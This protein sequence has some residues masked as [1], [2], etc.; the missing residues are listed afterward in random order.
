MRLSPPLALAGVVL[1]MIFTVVAAVAVYGGVRL[2]TIQA[3]D[4]AALPAFDPLR[5]RPSPTPIGVVSVAQATPTAIAAAIPTAVGGEPEPT[6]EV[7]VDPAAGYSAWSDPNRVNILLLGIDQRRGEQG[8]FR[9]DT[10]IVLSVDPVR[11]SAVMLSI[12]RDLWVS[13][14]GFAPGRIN[15]ANSLGD[16]Y[17]F[18]G[19][20]PALAAQTVERNLGIRI[21]HTIRVNFDLFL[22]AVEAIAPVEICVTETIHDEAYPDGSYGIMTV[23]FDPGCQPMNAEQLLQYARVRHTQGGDFDRARR[24]QQ[25]ITAARDR[26][27]SLGGVQALL[28]Q[29]PALWEAARQDI[30]T[31]LSFEQLVSLALL[32]QDI[33][34]ENITQAVL[35][36]NYVYFETTAS[37]DQVLRLRGD[38]MRRLVSD[39]FNPVKM[40]QEDLRALAASETA[41]LSVVNGTTTQ[42]L[43]AE[44]RDWLQA[45]GFNVVEIGNAT[46]SGYAH[47]VIKD[48]TNKPYTARLLA[49]L[50]GLPVTAVQPGSDNATVQDIQIVVGE[51]L[52]PLL[53]GQ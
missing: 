11:R 42:G 47:T 21:H 41:T 29:A 24:Q 7:Q 17:D 12:P 48:Y 35:D 20:G 43:A 37:G 14:P 10:M 34:Q 3:G 44:A 2:L 25:V 26:I 33:P 18:P 1:L 45:R 28:A 23:H 4:I 31:T 30:Q 46:S 16:S 51:D 38:A 32:A 13:I 5:L 15:T 49:S 22:R 39:L 50:L 19:G 9:T 36:A 27:L 53:R 52:I 6:A 40:E 8:P